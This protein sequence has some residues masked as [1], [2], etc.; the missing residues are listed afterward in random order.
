MESKASLFIKMDTFRHH[1][2]NF[3]HGLKEFHT[4]KP[5]IEFFT[6]LLTIPVL[7][8]V[9]ILNLNN[10]KS[11]DKKD[12]PKNETIVITQ[13]AGDKE[14]EVI[15]KKE[16]CKAGIGDISIASPDENEEV[17]D[18]PVNV[19]INYDAGEY[20]TVVWSYRVNGGSWSSYDD[21]SIALYNLSNGNV[22]FELRVK[23][24]VNSAQENLTR[25]FEY[26]GASASITP[27]PTPS[28]SITP[29][30]TH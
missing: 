27:T 24:V 12:T 3:K 17:T 2:K 22:K 14:K 8:T 26:N 7:L 29:T 21:R 16:A 4:K 5:H 1:I 18:N 19:D 23:S 15:V 20:C 25:N 11:N 10:L 13:A 9:I 30:P 6:A 28:A